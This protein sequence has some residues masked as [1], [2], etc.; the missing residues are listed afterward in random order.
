MCVSHR[1]AFTPHSSKAFN[2]NSTLIFFLFS[3][4]ASRQQVI[5]QNTFDLTKLKTLGRQ[6]QNQRS[7]NI[8]GLQTEWSPWVFI[9][10]G[11]VALET[12]LIDADPPQPCWC[13]GP[14]ETS[15]TGHCSN[16]QEWSAVVH[17]CNVLQRIKPTCH[18]F[19]LVEDVLNRRNWPI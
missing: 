18:V 17:S 6:K 14:H 4:A 13:L 1:S 11:T 5:I 7:S 16:G 9:C 3:A 8:S 15:T 12:V 19:L 2:R 10:D